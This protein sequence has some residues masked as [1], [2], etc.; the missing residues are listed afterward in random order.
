MLIIAIFGVFVPVMRG[1]SFFD[2]MMM[3]AYACLG[4]LFGAPLAVGLFSKD[5]PQTMGEA[6]L[7]VLKSVGYGVA[8]TVVIIGVGLITANLRRSSGLRLPE[9]DTLCGSLVLALFASVACVLLA[10]WMALRFS[11]SVARTGLRFVFL[12]FVLAFFYWPT[13]LPEIWLEGTGVAV[14]VSIIMMMLLRREVS[15]R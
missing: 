8:M 7:R 14:A 3:A 9:L 10:G 11:Q 15:P 1:S 13:R 5:R 12:M 2:P 4:V 6:L